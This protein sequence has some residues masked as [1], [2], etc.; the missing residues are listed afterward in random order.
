MKKKVNYEEN[1]KTP[2]ILTKETYIMRGFL[3][4]NSKI[5]LANVMLTT[6][7]SSNFNRGNVNYEGILNEKIRYEEKSKL[8]GKFK[9]SSNLNKGNVHYDGI[10][11]GKKQDKSCYCNANN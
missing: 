7:G 9:D 10:L 8:R 6:K 2:Q 4:E 1:L 3:L 5:S 11:N